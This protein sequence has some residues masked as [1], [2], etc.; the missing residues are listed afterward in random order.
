MAYVD[1]LGVLKAQKILPDKAIGQKKE[2][3]R[4]THMTHCDFIY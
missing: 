4:R 3:T 2:V 1:K